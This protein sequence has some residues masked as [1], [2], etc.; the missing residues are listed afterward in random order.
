M[1]GDM[2]RYGEM[3]GDVEVD[4]ARRPGR[5]QQERHRRRHVLEQAGDRDEEHREAEDED[6]GL[7]GNHAE[8]RPPPVP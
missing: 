7:G 4:A 2:G 5:A 1:W 6:E 3:W 8:Q